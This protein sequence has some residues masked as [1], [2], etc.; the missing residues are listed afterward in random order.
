MPDELKD[1]RFGLR[2][3]VRRLDPARSGPGPPPARRPRPHRLHAGPRRGTRLDARDRG[4]RGD[5]QADRRSRQGSQGHLLVAGQPSRQR[6]R[7]GR[8]ADAVR[9]R[10]LRARRGHPRVRARLRE[11]E[12]D[13][14]L[15]FV[16]LCP[17][18]LRCRTQASS[19]PSWR[20]CSPGRPA[21]RAPGPGRADV[22][23]RALRPGAQLHDQDRRGA[24][25]HGASLEL[26]DFLRRTRPQRDGERVTALRGGHVYPERRRRRGRV[27]ARAEADNWLEASVSHSVA[28]VLPDGRRMVRD[29]RRLRARLA[30]G[31]RPALSRTPPS[32]SP[33]GTCRGP[34]RVRLQLIRRA[35]GGGIPVPGQEPRCVTRWERAAAWRSATCSARV[36]S[37][38]TSSAPGIRPA[39]PP[40]LPGPRLR[41]EPDHGPPFVREHFAA[42]VAALP[43][44]APCRPTSSRGRLCTPS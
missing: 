37:S 15:E 24:A 27:L 13:P 14:A 3:L 26:E 11:E 30:R 42:T 28:A 36:T 22:G 1:Q 8:P 10:A 44:G 41:P 18:G 31:D 20:S 39:E 38:S 25:P 33:R 34:H 2:F 23:A 40:V 16:E 7:L 9:G 12:P 29:R 43:A 32:T 21:P 6:G 35:S 4:E 5:H 19:T 17:S